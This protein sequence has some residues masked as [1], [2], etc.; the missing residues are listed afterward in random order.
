MVPA[1]EVN[2]AR[3]GVI[4]PAP[5]HGRMVEARLGIG[6]VLDGKVIESA[7]TRLDYRK[8]SITVLHDMMSGQTEVVA[9]A[10]PFITYIPKTITVIG[11]RQYR[12]WV[13][14]RWWNRVVGSPERM[15]E[16]EAEVLLRL[17]DAEPAAIRR[18]RQLP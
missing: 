9:D 10:S 18:C 8:P 14:E 3:R 15:N 5:L 6:G 2:I 7:S 12:I 11:V 4:E 13:D 17:I 1:G 16:F